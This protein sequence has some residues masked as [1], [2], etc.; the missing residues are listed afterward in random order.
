M[1][2]GKMDA[3]KIGD[4]SD[5]TYQYYIIT[6]IQRVTDLIMLYSYD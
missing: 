5:Y 4:L 3:E 1:T 6:F 2:I